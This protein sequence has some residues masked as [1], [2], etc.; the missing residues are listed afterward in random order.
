MT[1][2]YPKMCR[3]CAHS[4]PDKDSPWELHCLHPVVNS[5]DP[6]ALATVQPRGTN[7]L[8]ERAKDGL[9]WW[10]KPCGMRGALWEPKP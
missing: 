10:R 7:A 6:W 5:K 8:H 1:T 9:L 2:P 3:D 4:S